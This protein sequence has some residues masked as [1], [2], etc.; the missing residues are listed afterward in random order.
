M[1]VE[2]TDQ[3]SQQNEGQQNNNYPSAQY[4]VDACFQDY[5]R[6]HDTYNKLYEKLNVALA[7]SGVVLTIV[8]GTLDFTP[9][10][11][12]VDGL[13]IWEILLKIVHA[14]CAIGSPILL[15]Y[16]TICLLVLLKGKKLTVFKSEDI[17]NDEVYREEEQNAAM[18]LIDKYTI[19]INEIRPIISEKQKKFEQALRVTVIGLILYAVVLVFGKVGF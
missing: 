11:M 6:L 10:L 14:L 1:E 9:A 17:R 15:L 12:K 16:G 13:Q 8:L 7:F 4:L 3:S 5:M 18:W 2:N 19:C